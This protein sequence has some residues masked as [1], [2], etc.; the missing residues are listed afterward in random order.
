MH[1]SHE[2][3]QQLLSLLQHLAGHTHDLMHA[4]RD[5]AAGADAAAAAA[6]TSSVQEQLQELQEAYRELQ[7]KHG[8]LTVSGPGS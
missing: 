4:N 1:A 8:R 3:D 2:V 6:E 5:A 7:D